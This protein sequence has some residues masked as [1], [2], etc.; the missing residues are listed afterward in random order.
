ME[1]LCPLENQ[2]LRHLFSTSG[3]GSWLGESLQTDS[4]GEPVMYFVRVSL[5]V[6]RFFKGCLLT[7]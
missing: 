2:E 4:S 5:E 6:Q 3:Y 7:L 1:V